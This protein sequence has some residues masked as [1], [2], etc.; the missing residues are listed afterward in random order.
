[1]QLSKSNYMQYLRHPALLWLSKHDPDKLPPVDDSLQAMFNAGHK[2][3]A[4]AEALFS[5]GVT[6]GFNDYTEYQSLPA[7]TLQALANGHKTIFQSRFV[8]GE[9]NCLPDIINV[10]GKNAASENAPGKNTASEK[11]IDLYEIKSSTGVKK[12]HLYD[13]AF[14]T[15]V[16]EGNGLKVRDI[17]VIYV[18]N[19]YVRQGEIVPKE[20]T[21]TENVTQAVRDLES[22]TNE[23]MPL[24]LDTLK[25]N[26]MPNPSPEL[27]GLLG[28]KSEWQKIYDSLQGIT[29]PDYANARPTI[30]KDKI[31]D[32]LNT[33]TYPLYFLDYET[34]ASVVPYFNGHRPYMQVPSQY[35][36]HI[37]DSPTA[38]LRHKEYLHRDNSDPSL[39]LAQHL[40]EDIGNSGSIIAWN[41]GFEKSF[42]GCCSF[43]KLCRTSH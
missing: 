26:T 11:E 13:L 5:D 30:Q 8:W 23:N 43:F 2:F 28:S 37:L 34:M 27:L 25:S 20:L 17:Y 1:M 35:S 33:L 14:Q 19:Q 40:I 31:K 4:Y 7:R 12:D 16:I 39:P 18:N 9:Y 24:A 29:Q 22:F 32:F 10:V 6:L 21:S 36:L 42:A 15:A 3:E 38:K 41:M